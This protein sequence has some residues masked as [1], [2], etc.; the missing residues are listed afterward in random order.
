MKKSFWVAAVI[1]GAILSVNYAARAV[2]TE[3]TARPPEGNTP[4]PVVN[5]FTQC[6]GGCFNDPITYLRWDSA[7]RPATDW[8]TANSICHQLSARL[9]TV[10]DLAHL[11][12]RDGQLKWADELSFERTETGGFFS[13]KNK[14]TIWGF[15]VNGTHI[16]VTHLDGRYSFV[17]VN[18]L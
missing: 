17:C 11:N 15:I 4:P 5:R 14:D 1:I 8:V 9:P 12:L 6:S 10:G 7:V 16:G 3:P 2:F 13:N 18:G